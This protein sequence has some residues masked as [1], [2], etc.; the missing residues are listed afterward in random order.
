MN[1]FF[2]LASVFLAFFALAA[3]QTPPPAQAFPDL[4]W[5]H[6]KPYVFNVA[7]I[8]IKSDFKPDFKAPHVEHLFPLALDKA[9]MRWAEDRLHAGGAPERG[10]RVVF[11]VNKAEAVEALL[12]KKKG[13]EGYFTD[14]ESE[15]YNLSIEVSLEVLDER[16]YRSG[17]V[18]AGAK[19]S[20]SVLEDIT[21]D[22]REKVW[23]EMT[24]S[25][26]QELN[27]QL[28]ANIKAYLGGFLL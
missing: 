1:R 13:V 8:E 6:L 3:C 11:T 17:Y 24:E 26:M 9:A 27:S 23:F 12:E 16:G 15:Q 19:R 7:E 2:P 4:T 14:E 5:T 18:V 10:G 20:Q 25:L 28:E 22:E 21:L